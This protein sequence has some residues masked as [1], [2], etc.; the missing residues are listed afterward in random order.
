MGGL[1]VGSE[2][3]P[4]TKSSLYLE[5]TCSDHFLFLVLLKL[6]VLIHDIMLSGQNSVYF[7]IN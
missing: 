4:N 2:K 7:P 1:K 5:V 6:K 3:S